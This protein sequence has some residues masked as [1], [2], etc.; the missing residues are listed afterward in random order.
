M[1]TLFTEFKNKKDLSF[2]AIYTQWQFHLIVISTN[3]HF[4]SNCLTFIS[5]NCHWV[6]VSLV[7]QFPF[8]LIVISSD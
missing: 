6:Q 5:L 3:C 7:V 4:S 2:Y 1:I 8:D